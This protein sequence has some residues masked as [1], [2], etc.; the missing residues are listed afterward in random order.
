MLSCSLHAEVF[1][2]PRN[3]RGKHHER[4]SGLIVSLLTCILRGDYDG[5]R[6]WICWEPELVQPFTNAPVPKAP[7]V[8]HYGIEKD[9]HKVSDFLNT[10]GKLDIDAFLYHAFDFNMR[11]TMLGACTF[12]YEA[13]C[14]KN[15]PNRNFAHSH[16]LAYLL[17][18]LVDSTKGGL[19]FDE[20]AWQA[21]RS[22]WKLPQVPKPAYKD[23]RAARPTKHVID[24]LVFET[25][26]GV[27]DKALKDF[28]NRF[29]D[30]GRWDEDLARV[31][32][33]ELEDS[34]RKDGGEESKLLAAVLTDLLDRLASIHETWMKNPL[35]A[36]EDGRSKS[37]AMTFRALV[38][39]CRDDFLELEP[40][41]CACSRAKIWKRDGHDG[42]WGL[43]KA[44]ALFNKYS[45]GNFAWHVAGVELGEIKARARKRGGY[46]CVVSNIH[47]AMKVD[48][49]AVNGLI[50][51]EKGE[52]ELEEDDDD[53]YGSLFDFAGLDGLD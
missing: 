20:Q 29:Q 26:R 53:D 22:K 48:R 27:K 39:K 33:I 35:N 6:A 50:W 15:Y 40:L 3:Y 9:K 34:K 52:E 49:K 14:Y 46:R 30:A 13:L 8:E 16:D 44:S 17:G 18:Y 19:R 11:I 7:R 24:R 28:A 43:L 42:H 21:L 1:H 37:N 4:N 2:W 36:D 31:W 32:K 41:N 5:D 23:P 10:S 47:E 12:H 25:A 38:E 45:S 51:R